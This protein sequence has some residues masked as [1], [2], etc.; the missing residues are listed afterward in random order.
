[1]TDN[2]Y[3]EITNIDRMNNEHNQ[4]ESYSTEEAAY[5]VPNDNIQVKCKPFISSRFDRIIFLFSEAV[6]RRCFIN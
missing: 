1:M 5:I 3:Y 4:N 2:I 6:I